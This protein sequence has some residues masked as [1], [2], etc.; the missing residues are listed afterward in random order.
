MKDQLNYSSGIE[1]LSDSDTCSCG[2]RL[3]WQREQ[4][5]DYLFEYVGYCRE[6]GNTYVEA[7]YG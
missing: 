3:D 2:G 7:N 1:E 5:D 6:C 4:R